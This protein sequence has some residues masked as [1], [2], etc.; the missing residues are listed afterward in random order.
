MSRPSDVFH[1][2]RYLVK[3]YVEVN[4]DFAI[5]DKALKSAWIN[6]IQ[7]QSPASWKIIP[8]HLLRCHGNLAF[9]INCN[10]D[11]KTLKLDD[12][13]A[14]YYSILEYWQYFKTLSVNETNIK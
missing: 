1:L 7:N 12:L 9:L 8:D 10:Y 6:W 4:Y 5:M 3:V 11:T 13:P 2:Q 14:F